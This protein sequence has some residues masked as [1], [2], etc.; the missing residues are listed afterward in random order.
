MRRIAGS[1][2]DRP[3]VEL[4]PIERPVPYEGNPRNCT[5][6]AIAKVAASIKEFGF[7]QAIVV[8][9]DDIVVVGHTRLLAA[10]QLGLTK[11]PVHVAAHL[12][13]AQ[14]AAYRI[15]DNRT[16]E[17]TSWN[18]ELL[19]VEIS[20]LISMD[21]E[22]DVLGF[23]SDELAEL[24][25]PPVAGLVDPDSV[26]ETPV[27]PVTKPGDI[28]I[29]GDHRLLCGDCTDPGM[30]AKVMDGEQATLMATDPP[31]LVDY[32][33]GNHPPTWANG[34]KRPGAAPD[35]ATKHWDTYIDHEDGGQVLREL[36][37]GRAH[38]GAGQDAGDLHVLRHD[39]GAAGLCGLGARRPAVAPGTGLVQDPHRALALGFLLELRTDRLRLDQGVKATR[40][41]AATGQ[42]HR[43][44]GDPLDDHRRTAGT[45]HRQAGRARA[46]AAR[47]PHQGRR[48]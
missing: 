16:G 6:E 2:H 48:G 28:W 34:G 11:V 23:D 41:T 32:D 22:I 36:P 20:K 25:A 45:P 39:A 35:A 21:Y 47:V 31:Y 40:R 38:N 1:S 44:L 37:H 42:R 3:A 15:A 4:W 5:P 26:P 24:L 12:S 17:E 13:P 18:E 19:S 30:V 14:V 46:P 10:K 27:E 8:D 7:M 9:K 33:G 43:D 29:L